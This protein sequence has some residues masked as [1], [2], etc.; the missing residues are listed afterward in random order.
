MSSFRQSENEEETKT[1]KKNFLMREQR[2]R[3][4]GLPDGTYIFQ[5]KNPNLGKFWNALHG[6]ILVY[7][8]RF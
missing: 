4:T 5:A 3:P 6:K 7:F 2:L 8:S 1:L